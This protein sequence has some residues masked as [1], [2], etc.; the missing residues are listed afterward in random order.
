MLPDH[1]ENALARLARP[2][3]GRAARV[4][5]E[6]RGV[7]SVDRVWA[8]CARA[9]FPWHPRPTRAWYAAERYAKTVKE[10]V[11]RGFKSFMAQ[12][13]V[14][15]SR[16]PTGPSPTR[17]HPAEVA[18]LVRAAPSPAAAAKARDDFFRFHF[19][20]SCHNSR[21]GIRDVVDRPCACRACLRKAEWMV[22]ALLP[23]A[24]L[25]ALIG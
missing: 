19:C 6:W 10:F 14:Y 7:A 8:R 12:C 17:F 24:G 18:A 2:D 15:P 3:L 5:R 13:Y 1:L 20:P 16:A 25:E 4:C 22:R 11:R 9:E 21:T 23:L